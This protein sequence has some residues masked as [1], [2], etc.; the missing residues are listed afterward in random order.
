MVSTEITASWPLTLSPPRTTMLVSPPNGRPRMPELNSVT[1]LPSSQVSG[2]PFSSQSIMGSVASHSSGMP[3]PLQSSEMPNA[4]S[5]SSGMKLALQ[6][7]ESPMV[8]SHESGMRFPLQSVENPEAISHASGMPFSLQSGAIPSSISQLSTTP[9]SL[10]SSVGSSMSHSSGTPLLLQS[11]EPSG[12]SCM[13]AAA[14]SR[15]TS[16]SPRSI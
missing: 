16:A 9:L 1:G 13:M 14:I 11:M 12:R 10:Q 15:P 8:M 2:T 5:H 7:S 3:L 6:S 4:T